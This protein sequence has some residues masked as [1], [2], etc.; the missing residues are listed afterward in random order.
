[1]VARKVSGCSALC[2]SGG[3]QTS[4]FTSVCL[5]STEQLLMVAVDSVAQAINHNM[6]VCVEFLDLWKAFD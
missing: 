2:P 1:M 6:S 3:A 5:S 4:Q